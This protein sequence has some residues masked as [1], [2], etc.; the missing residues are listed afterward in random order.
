MQHSI[1]QIAANNSQISQLR[2]DKKRFNADE[3]IEFAKLNKEKFH[4]EDSLGELWV[5]TW[6][7]DDLIS[8]FK[9]EK[10]LNNKP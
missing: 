3:F 6:F 7:S 4:L 5:S 1:K 2:K 9:K 10:G 8:A